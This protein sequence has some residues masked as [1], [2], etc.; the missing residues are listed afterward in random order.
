MSQRIPPPPPGFVIQ[1]P[2]DTVPPP[3]PGFVIDGAP[4]EE[5]PGLVSRAGTAIANA[6]RG[7]A[8]EQAPQALA[9]M[10]Y[11]RARSAT[12]DQRGWLDNVRQEGRE[13]GAS[14]FGDDADLAKTL[15]Q[16]VEGAKV[17]ND[18]SG[19]PMIE[20]PDG[21][22]IYANQPGADPTDVLRFAGQLAAYAPAAK[23]GQVIGG[24]STLARAAITGLLSGATNA[25]GQVA[26]GR[27]QIDANE[28]TTTAV[29]G[30]LGEVA[31]KVIPAA[32]NAV[33]SALPRSASAEQR[34][35]RL[36]SELGI[37]APTNAQVRSLASAVDEIDAG[38]DPRAIL[39]Q[40]RFGFLY[41]TGQRLTPDDPRKFDLLA[42]EEVLRQT[43]TEAVPR[44]GAG[45]NAPAALRS[46]VDTNQERLG[47]AVTRIS[48]DLGAA[49]GVLSPAQAMARAQQ[50]AQAQ[51]QG[52]RERV[53]TAYEAASASNRSA[54]SREAAQAIPQRVQTALREF[55]INPQLTPA[56]A[57][58]L[59]T[60]RKAVEALP[61]NAKG[62]T[63]RALEQQRRIIGNN[64]GAAA[65]ATD[66][67]AL[68]V[69]R[70]EYDAAIGDAFE[71]ALISG[72]DAA[73]A[74]LKEARSLRAELGRRFEGD[75]QVDRFITDLIDGNKTP[76]ELV[77]VALGASNVSNAASAR[78]I[79]RLKLATA[80]DESV[81]G[82]MRAAHFMKLVQ[83]K[84]GEPLGMQVI[85]NNIAS[86]ERNTGELIRQLYTDDQWRSVKQLAE[87]VQPLLARG[88]FRNATGGGQGLRGAIQMAM[89]RLPAG[90][91][92]NLARWLQFGGEDPFAMVT[93]PVRTAP[94]SVAAA[95]AAAA[96]TDRDQQQP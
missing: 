65:N 23:A 7:D 89:N 6:W 13:L 63:L 93:K 37:T 84:T 81:L 19:N 59:E 70:R 46:A 42:R 26:A 10:D 83:S 28:A 62:V 52:L 34:A 85:V 50:T 71:S 31:A 94:R 12:Q 72:D 9:S 35:V 3:P 60:M 68:S 17:V 29:F 27:D 58:T 4:E 16:G 11:L 56:T 86:T 1:Q 33:R 77:N 54:A 69:L 22:R 15:A 48:R 87:A 88:D 76:D 80:G 82:A 5:K 20:L 53:S 61:A 91:R 96:P 30:A 40:E 2:T 73:L 74:T 78:F 90:A 92:E 66:R 55:D 8:A 41:T 67:A 75:A 43:P 44:L 36:A 47:E 24:G 95:S 32:W 21:K 45:P 57:R 25:G 79:E 39:G 51:A 14:V 38:A 18:A 64:F 49:E